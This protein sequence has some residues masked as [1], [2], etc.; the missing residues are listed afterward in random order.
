M[1]QSVDTKIVELKFNN[2]NFADKVDSTL[3]KLEQLNKDIEKVG[4]TE[5]FK[6]LGKSVKDVDTKSITDGVNETHKAFSKM[7]VVGLTALANLSN[8]AVNFGKKMVKNL[9]SPITKGVMQGGLARARNIEQ[10]TFSFEGQKISKSAGNEAKSYYEEVMQAVLGTSYSYDVAAKAASQ[11]AASNVGVIDTEKKLADGSTITSKVLDSSMT[12]ALLGIAGVAAMTGSDFDSIAQIFTRVAGQGRVMANDLNSISSRGLN[13]AAVL[14]KYLDTTEENVRDMVTK[15]K[16]SFEDFSN[17]MTQAFGTHAKDS[18]LTF[19]GALDDVNAALARIGADFYGPA[20][21]AGRDI[22]NSITPLVD[23]IHSKLNPALSSTTNL[24][25]EASGKM[26]QYLDMLSYMLNLTDKSS[27]KDGWIEEHM[28]AWTNIADLYKTG[29][30]KDAIDGLEKASAAWKGMDGQGINGRQMV[31]DYYN[32]ASNVDLLSHYLKISKDD[33]KALVDEGSV[34]AKEI[35]KVLNGML[36][37]GTIGW[38]EFYK[39]FHKLWSESENLMG[40]AKVQTFFDEY[41]RSCIAAGQESKRFTQHI[42]TFFKIYDGLASLFNSLK[43]IAGGFL[44][45][46]MTLAQHLAPLGKLVIDFTAAFAT[47]IVGLA[48][49]ISTSETFANVIDSIVNLLT[50]LFTALHLN[51]VADIALGGITKTFDFLANAIERVHEGMGKVITTFNNT[52]GKVIDKIQEILSNAEEVQRILDSIK[53]AGITVMLIQLIGAITKPAE[54]LGALAKSIKDVGGSLDKL[55]G[56]I[57]DVFKSISG[58][59]GNIGD[60]IKE[61]AGA[62]HE[63]QTLVKA[64]AILEIALAVAVL[65]GA[66]YLLSKAHASEATSSLVGFVEVFAILLSLVGSVAFLKKIKSTAKLWEKATDSIKDIGTAMLEMAASILVIA[67]AMKL[68][69]TIKTD[70]MMAAFAVVEVLLITMAGIAKLLQEKTTKDTGLKALWSGKQTSTG[71]ITKG[72]MGL[73]AMAEAVKIVS[74]ALVSIAQ[75]TDR[76]AVWSALGIVEIIMWSM[77]GIVKLLSNSKPDKMTKGIGSLLAMAI[78][79]RLLTKPIKELA[80]IANTDNDALWSATTL[81]GGLMFAMTGLLKWLSGTKGMLGEAVSILIMAEAIKILGQT[82]KSMA[83]AAALDNDALWSGLGVIAFGL[84]AMVLALDLLDGDKLIAKSIA[85]LAVAEA[86]RML[87]EVIL[88]FSAAGDSAWDGLGVLAVSLIVLFIAVEV[89]SKAPIGGI[90]KLFLTLA[91]GIVIV[92]GFGAAI[93][94]FGVGISIF[95]AG[96]TSLASGCE[97][98]YAVLPAFLTVMGMFIVSITVLSTIGAPAVLVILGL[99]AAFL[100]LGGGIALMGAGLENIASAIKL[101]SDL[102]GKLGKTAKNIRAFVKELSKMKGDVKTVSSAA[103]SITHSFSRIA[104]AALKAKVNTS[105]FNTVGQQLASNLAKGIQAGSTQVINTVTS[106]SNTAVSKLSSSRSEWY[107]IGSYLIAGMVSGIASQ[108]SSLESQVQ[109]L[110]AKAERAVRAKAKIKSPSRVWMQIGSYM[111]QGLA[112]GIKNSSDF[113]EEASKGLAETS[114]DAIQSA[115]TSISNAMDSDLDNTLTIKPVVD[116]SDVTS[117]ANYI[118]S[119]FGTMGIGASLA[120][121]ISGNIQNGSKDSAI[122]KLANKLDA[123]TESM[124]SRSLNV[125]NTIDGAS[126]PEAFADG[127]IRSF[128]LNART[129]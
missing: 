57:G 94:V 18:T 104:N 43:T 47:F 61:L 101:M 24:I 16:V 32:L 23:V 80:E 67:L 108:Q 84:G 11:L 89:F 70:D 102:E 46:L 123:M 109:S 5:A 120:G 63:L 48:D 92:A 88:S 31:A 30:V 13:A 20:L 85:L 9:V 3:T 112:I 118:N 106:M 34:G 66:I 25:T 17:A 121:A 29:N 35:N 95:G 44:D 100:M 128:R 56:N 96:L 51:K 125:Y 116:L 74:K 93:G 82:L 117:S 110:E 126:D 71:G 19:Q 41:V 105:V 12:D 22:L 28:N 111:G 2:D 50:K 62:L 39:S 75:E 73:I 99:G 86:L 129:T 76:D 114:E 79:I 72:L 113:V 27:T 21:T 53:T 87:S 65:A 45:I 59:L 14:A 54:L 52:V 36:K 15:G 10:A 115:I 83:E 107:D 33:A 97:A 124:N 78:S 7:E 6:N 26:S 60:V 64:T 122:N 77:T 40:M 1:A 98:V 8:A 58:L 103:D 68:L 38:N 69:S 127:L 55:V 42:Q 81:I 49:A 37:D 4:F 119:R 91:L 90:L